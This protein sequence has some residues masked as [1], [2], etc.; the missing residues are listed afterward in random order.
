LGEEP[1]EH[2]YVCAKGAGTAA[3]YQ[4]GSLNCAVSVRLGKG[5]CL[6]KQLL[7]PTFLLAPLSYPFLDKFF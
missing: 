3:R 6:E 2:P 5:V 1:V 7:L 4:F